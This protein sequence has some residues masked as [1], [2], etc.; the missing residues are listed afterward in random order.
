[1]QISREIEE[2]KD[3]AEADQSFPVDD[4]GGG[5]AAAA[6]SQ[7]TPPKL[8][9]AFA[10]TLAAGQ[11]PVAAIKGPV[12]KK[13]R[14]ARL[15]V[16]ELQDYAT[17]LNVLRSR[18]KLQLK[19]FE[20]DDL[21]AAGDAWKER[22]TLGWEKHNVVVTGVKNGHPYRA[23]RLW[24]EEYRLF[25]EQLASAFVSVLTSIDGLRS[26]QRKSP[27]PLWKLICEPHLSTF[28]KWIGHQYLHDAQLANQWGGRSEGHVA[29]AMS[30]R[31]AM[32]YFEA[33]P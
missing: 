26:G 32:S 17:F 1:M 5:A 11:R 21:V 31:D 13:A 29:L 25:P 19:L 6:G 4:A 27:I 8:S 22:S 2:E 7:A 14:F 28:A 18:A 12:S 15:D 3:E 24:L 30:T 10:N 33:L 9:S 20:D 23:V 16:P